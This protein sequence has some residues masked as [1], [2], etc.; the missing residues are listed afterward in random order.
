MCKNSICTLKDWLDVTTQALCRDLPVVHENANN[1]F[2][3]RSCGFA[4][5]KFYSCQP[6]ANFLPNKISSPSINLHLLAFGRSASNVLLKM[7]EY[8]SYLISDSNIG[9]ELQMYN[10]NDIIM[11][12]MLAKY[13]ETHK[14]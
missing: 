5:F 14:V 8:T 1:P 4:S 6:F 2:R 12:N 7:H 11:I 9:L 13:D 3:T 10:L